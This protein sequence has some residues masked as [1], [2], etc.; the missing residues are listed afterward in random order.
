MMKHALQCRDTNHII[1]FLY[2]MSWHKN[3]RLEFVLW[4]SDSFH[5]L[6]FLHLI[7]MVPAPFF[8]QKDLWYSNRRPPKL[9]QGFY[10]CISFPSWAADD[11]YLLAHFPDKGM[12][13]QLRSNV[14]GLCVAVLK[15]GEKNYYSLV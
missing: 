10:L 14:W 8:F 2:I 11:L 7:F 9:K 4:H 3:K 1:D 15:R 6:I 5:L 13:N 12:K